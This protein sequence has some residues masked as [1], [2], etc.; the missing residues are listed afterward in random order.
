MGTIHIPNAAHLGTAAHVMRQAGDWSFSD[1]SAR[2]VFHDRWAYLQPWVIAAIATWGLR[3]RAD[4][5]E[6]E[7]E[8][9]HRAGWAW[10]FGLHKMLD[11]EPPT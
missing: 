3:A 4:G 10:R 7:V 1:Q 5:L 6:V 2:L 9:G 11:V 8:H